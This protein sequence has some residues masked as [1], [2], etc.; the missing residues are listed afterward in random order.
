MAYQ[1]DNI[2]GWMWQ[3]GIPG[4]NHPDLLW[5]GLTDNMLAIA[6]AYSD[7][8]STVSPRYA[9]EIQYPYMG[10][11]LDSLVRS[12]GNDMVGI[13]NG[14]DVDL[15]DPETDKLIVSNY[16][17]DNFVEDIS[18]A[19]F[20]IQ[21]SDPYL[22]YRN[23]SNEIIGIWFYNSAEREQVAKMIR[24]FWSRRFASRRF[25]VRKFLSNN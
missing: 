21:D 12:R 22:M 11:G 3:L 25:F 8:A 17:A 14:L 1:G 24:R 19:S 7:K 23:Q 5:R 2:G 13:L 18:T 9:T 6:I 15:W 4:R 16:N 10:Y 20:Q